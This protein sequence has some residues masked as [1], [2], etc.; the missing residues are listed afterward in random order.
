MMV[1]GVSAE[2]APPATLSWAHN[3]RITYVGCEN[4]P[5]VAGYPN[6]NYQ[7]TC[8]FGTD[9]PAPVGPSGCQSTEFRF[10]TSWAN[11]KSVLATVTAAYLSGRAVGIEV[12]DTCNDAFSA[13]PSFN[14]IVMGW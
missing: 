14:A 7:H 8:F 4:L 3:V 11:G 12:S 5:G 2:A 10:N 13:Y 9:L 1:L 6:E